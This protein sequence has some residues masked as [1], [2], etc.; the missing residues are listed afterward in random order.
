M[1]PDAN[2]DEQKRL[3][4][5]LLVKD[6]DCRCGNIDPE[7]AERLAEL[8]L[9]LDEWITKGGFPPKAWKASKT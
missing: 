6:A 8:V 3:A 4:K 2:L 1:D 5:E 7:K 9:A